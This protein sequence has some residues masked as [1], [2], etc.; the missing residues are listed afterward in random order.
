MIAWVLGGV[1]PSAEGGITKAHVETFGW[2]GY[3]H[4][5]NCGDDLMECVCAS[6]LIKL[7]TLNRCGFLPVHYTSVEL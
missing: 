5:L 4:C 1:G 6:K 3:V 2:N 7:C